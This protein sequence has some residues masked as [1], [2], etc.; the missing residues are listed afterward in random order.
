M[1]AA[2]TGISTLPAA[3]SRVRLM[4]D[5]AAT[6]APPAERRYRSLQEALAASTRDEGAVLLRADVIDEPRPAGS[7]SAIAVLA[8][9]RSIASFVAD[10]VALD[11]AAGV[12]LDFSGARAPSAGFIDEIVDDLRCHGIDIRVGDA[13]GLPLSTAS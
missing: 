11:I 8:R 2:M 7:E 10:I 1:S 5:R 13:A 3:S 9:P 12:V 6:G 4:V